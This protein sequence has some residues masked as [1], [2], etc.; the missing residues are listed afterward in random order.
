VADSGYLSVFGH[1]DIRERLSRAVE[2]GRL[3]QSLLMHGPRGI[4]K[5]RLALWTAAALNCRGGPPRPCGACAACRLSDRLEHPDIHWFFPLPRPKKASSAE[6]LQQKLED[7]RAAALEE[8]RSNPLYVAEEDGATGIYVAAVHTMRR[9][10]QKAPVTGPAKVLIIGH[11]EALTPQMASP[12]AANA[13]LKLLEEPPADTTLILTAEA[14]GA[15]LPTV[16]SRVQAVR[17]AP[18]ASDRVAEFLRV[19]L[20]VPDDDAVRLAARSSGSIGRALELRHDDRES[21]RQGASALVR[22]LLSERLPIQL[23]A[24]HGFRPFGA[25]GAFGQILSAA[26]SLLRDLLAAAA[27]ADGAV[28]DRDAISSLV[29]G[30]APELRR[31][32]QA[33]EALDEADG[34]AERNVNPQLIVAN[35]PRLGSGFRAGTVARPGES[36][37]RY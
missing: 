1:Q 19:E 20:H 5:Q 13:L 16:R 30:P 17:V 27:G 23:A 11:A 35:L 3:P 36:T 12:E 24:A 6:Q 29:P 32:V 2:L 28:S 26:R 21:V 37:R 31:I 9:L 8:R 4:G 7:L 15:L 25:R 22:A 33:L 34:L 18:L 10:A 14:P